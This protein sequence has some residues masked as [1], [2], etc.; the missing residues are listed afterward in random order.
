MIP[1][2]Y[3][4]TCPKVVLFDWDNTLVD[5][6]RVILDSINYTLELYEMPILTVDEFWARPHH[7]VRDASKELFG[8]D[9]LRAVD[10]YYERVKEKHL[11]NLQVMEGAHELLD[12][13]ATRGIFVGIVSNKQGEILRRESTHLGWDHHFGS[14]VGSLDTPED[15]PSALPGLHAL[16]PS[17]V[18]PG[19]DVWFVGD[20]IVDVLCAKAMNAVPVVVGEGDASKESDIIQ[21]GTCKTLANIISSL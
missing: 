12:L 16:K 7:S 1:S 17:F 15:K 21:A 20:S 10:I 19:H 14:I 4:Q 6:W 18:D 9:H 11:E 13:L 8:H 5:N 3:P 2:L